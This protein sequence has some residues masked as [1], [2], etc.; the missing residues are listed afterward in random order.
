[1]NA[2]SDY[3]KISSDE[4]LQMVEIDIVLSFDEF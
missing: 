2:G 4:E 1:M 3:T